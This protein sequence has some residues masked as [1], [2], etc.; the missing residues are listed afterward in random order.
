[1]TP[2]PTLT[3]TFANPCI[4]LTLYNVN[5]RDYPALE[6]TQVLLTIPFETT[7]TLYAKF[8]DGAWWLTE[9]EG[10]SGWVNGDFIRRAD[11]CDDL[12]NRQP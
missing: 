8:E 12:P 5:L 2:T 4:A 1:M 10:Q 6:D 9:W 11:S 3:P 7:L